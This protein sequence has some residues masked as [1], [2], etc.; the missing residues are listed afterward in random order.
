MK[1]ELIFPL[2]FLC[3]T[4]ICN[5]VVYAE[6]PVSEKQAIRVIFNS[7][8]YW[9]PSSENECLWAEV[10]CDDSHVTDLVLSAKGLTD[11]PEE[12][13]QLTQITRLDLSKN[14]LTALPD[15]FGQ[16]QMLTELNLSMNQLSTLP[17]SIG[18]LKKLLTLDVGNNKLGE[19][20]PDPRQTRQLDPPDPNNS[21]IPESPLA[22][23]EQLTQLITLKLNGNMFK[24]MPFNLNALTALETVSLNNNQL[25]D[26]SAMTL[27]T[28]LKILN[29]NQNEITSLPE[30]MNNFSTLQEFNL[31]NNKLEIISDAIGQLTALTSLSITNNILISISEQIGSLNV[32][33]KLALTNNKLTS[34]PSSISKLSA[35]TTLT[36][37][38]NELKSLPETIANLNQLVSLILSDNQLK[39]LPDDFGSLDT[40]KTLEIENND[41]ETLPESFG[42]LGKLETLNLSNNQLKAL[43]PS[44]GQLMHLQYLNLS[45]NQLNQ[46]PDEFCQLKSLQTL[47][48]TANHLESLPLDFGQLR[49]LRYLYGSSNALNE[50]PED[51]AALKSI[52]EL[53]LSNNHIRSLPDTFG[54]LETLQT[55]I[56]SS[57]TI[58]ALPY[59]FGQLENLQT[60]DLSNNRLFEIPD[61]FGELSFLSHLDLSNNQLRLL[62][63]ALGK[64]SN[65]LWLDLSNNT[66][67]VIPSSFGQL[68]RLFTLDLSHNTIKAL[69]PEIGAL[70]NLRTLSLADNKFEAFQDIVLLF[71]RL[72][73]LNL[74][75]NLSM[76]GSIP[77]N[78]S[79][80]N[81]LID[82]QL[83]NTA[84]YTYSQKMADFINERCSACT[85]SPEETKILS[86]DNALILAGVTSTTDE[87]KLFKASDG[88]D[89]VLLFNAPV[90]LES[91]SLVI[92][93]NTGYTTTISDFDTYMDSVNCTYTIRDEDSSE[94]LNLSQVTLSGGTLTDASGRNA[95]LDLPIGA[96]LADNKILTI[97]G[98]PPEVTITQPE[99]GQC[100]DYL[101]MIKGT[102]SD[103]F[104]IKTI[105]ITVTDGNNSSNSVP[106]EL[107]QNSWNVD[108]VEISWQPDTPSGESPLT[109]VVFALQENVSY[110]INVL[111]EDNVGNTA[112]AQTTFTYKKQTS[113]ISCN[114][115]DNRLTV[116]E[117]LI[118]T[119]T[120]VPA[121]TVISDIFIEMKSDT[122][123]VK[124][125]KIVTNRDGSFSY[126]SECEDFHQ[127]GL[128]QIKTIFEGGTCIDASESDY[129]SITFVK[130][131]TEIVLDT[132]DDAIRKGDVFS[133]SGKLTPSPDCNA[134]LTGLNLLLYINGPDQL[135][136]IVME[137]TVETQYG[138][139]LTNDFDLS[140]QYPDQD[141]TGHWS[142]SAY[143]PETDSYQSSTSSSMSVI[144][145]ESAGYAIIIQGKIS[146]EEGLASHQKTSDFVYNQ[147]INRGLQDT[148]DN[149]S[150]HDIQYF[151][152]AAPGASGYTYIDN[153]PSKELIKE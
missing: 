34:L 96:N 89:I 148:N 26:F 134:N 145:L 123:I 45:D 38:T 37:N 13:N 144:V 61:D 138:H 115:S 135:K 12:I 117:T 80:L 59:S 136:P 130:A 30:N 71:T 52:Q 25:T 113:Q 79:N 16:L 73:S 86:N 76:T 8:Q 14:K 105:D 128:W 27:L 140:A 22:Q 65:L 41:L 102:V 100:V 152:Y 3:L 90:K 150:L 64:L 106:Y 35:L 84:L 81:N 111:V 31:S 149:E 49:N 36:L 63:P 124:T 110:T 153:A 68:S 83:E 127:A 40:L 11:I 48:L 17:K 58:E 4:V 97:D 57:N 85:F 87:L 72:L 2:I 69:Q 143:F 6:I 50:L 125:K 51:F 10:T 141:I 119:G 142:V 151:S 60:L 121:D 74:S 20:F 44:L 122:G 7:I 131:E 120:I 33:K 93:F 107:K 88:I 75:N 19:S 133:I 137:A 114:L 139:F 92:T 95:I 53:Y 21:P 67:E 56:L 29:L 112:E 70:S 66:I 94:A 62:T 147:L 15:I 108:I 132:T 91:G 82:L 43:V 116:G 28:H 77:Y 98:V 126:T 47:Y 42:Q 101:D 78:F 23:L 5:H 103:T 24:Q 1:K 32:L 146:N 118:I 99:N 18:Q 9:E 39:A 55:L 54:Q 104:G 109:P 46:L 129:Q